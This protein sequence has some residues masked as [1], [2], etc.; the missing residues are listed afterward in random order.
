MYIWL[1]CYILSTFIYLI[2]M[3]IYCLL[4]QNNKSTQILVLKC[5][6]MSQILVIGLLK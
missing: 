6:I 5:I 4:L 2:L 3:F 1:L